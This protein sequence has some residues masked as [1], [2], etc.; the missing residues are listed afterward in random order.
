MTRSLSA[1]CALFL[2]L[3]ML[4]G[5]SAAPREQVFS[6]DALSITLT[7]S[8]ADL[9]Q[10]DFAQEVAFSYSDG[11][12]S[13]CGVRE[14]KAC[15]Q[16][17]LPHMDAT[18]YAQLFVQSNAL[19]SDGEGKSPSTVETEAGIPC[20]TYVIPGDP[21]IQYLCGVFAS[22]EHFWVVQLYCDRSCYEANRPDMWK[23][24]TSVTVQ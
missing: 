1:V 21:S 8:F 15:L 12:V 2:A 10:R 20:F 18:S 19:Y 22:R 24:L 9:S 6:C 3:S 4:S 11:A 5:C 7:D 16:A 14:E 23:Y 13:V 17:Y